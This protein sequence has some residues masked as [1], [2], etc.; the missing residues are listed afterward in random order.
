MA[1]VTARRAELAASGRTARSEVVWLETSADGYAAV[2]SQWLSWC[3]TGPVRE[4][5]P[6]DHGRLDDED[7]EEVFE[8]SIK[9]VREGAKVVR[10]IL[11]R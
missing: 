9:P 10:A 6:R 3:G 1:T 8:D 11:I 5:S 2:Y 4:L 7:G